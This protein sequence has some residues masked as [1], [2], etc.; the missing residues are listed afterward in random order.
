MKAVVM[1]GG[2]GSRLRPLTV[3][4][5]K[6]M[7]PIVGRPVMEHILHLLKEHGITD[8][9][10]TVQYMASA[11]EDYF[12]D[13]T[14]LGMRIAY[15][16]EEIPLGTAG[17]VKNAEHLL[18]EPFLVISGDAMTDYNLSD[19]IRYHQEKKAL[20]T[21]TLAHVAN[22]LEYGVITTGENG[23]IQQF[24]EKPSWGEVFSDTI[25][26]GIYVLDPKIF[27]YFE[28]ERVFDFSQDLFPMM[29]EK[30][31]PLYGY[32]AE[33]YWCDIGN[34]ATYM[35]AN[36]DLLHGR[37]NIPVPGTDIGGRVWVEEG[38]EIDPDAQI[39]GPV[40]L[41]HDC[42]IKGGVIVHGPSCVGPYTIADNHAQIDR[43][44][45]WNNSYIGE[46]A[47]LR[48]AL[49][50]TSCT[51]KG[52]AVMFE[53]AVIGDH[54]VINES[55]IVQA[56]VKIWPNKEIETGAVIANSIIWGS[57][58]RRALF[59]R[60]GVTGLVNVDIT[61][62]FAARLGAAYGAVLA[63]GAV[64]CVN[65]D[66]HRT[67]RMIKRA[68]ISGL[69]S[70][71]VNVWDLESVPLP[72]A[73]YY[74]RTTDAAGGVHIRLSPFDPRTVDIKFFDQ[75]GLDISKNIER[76]I[77]NLFF[78][79]DFRRVYL[80]DIG[81]ISYA[82]AVAERYTAAF[83]RAID[84]DLIRR[85]NF[86]LVVDYGHGAS[87]NILSPLFNAVSAD[88]IALNATRDPIRYSRTAEE[89]DRDK[90]VLASVT[91]TL[92]ADMGVRIDT[93]GER[94]YVV[95][96]LGRQID[97]GHLMGV[98]TDLI[99]R[100]QSGGSVVVPVTVPSVVEAI[101]GKQQGHITRTKV[102]PQALTTAAASDGTV[103]VGD[104]NG[105]FVFPELHPA[106]DGMFALMKL[107]EALARFNAKLSEVVDQL[108]P[109][110][111]IRTQVNCPWEYKGKVMRMLSEQYHKHRDEAID[112]VRIDL[113]PEEW[114]LVLPDADRPLFHVLAE[115]RSRDAAQALADKYARVVSGLQH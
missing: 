111:M 47:E 100:G 10:V 92:K 75:Y 52:K 6:P 8:V 42:K 79:E 85:R 80:D 4:R 103:L 49:V 99:L 73:R 28:K 13:G 72:V 48:G 44:V 9:V 58:G 70:A 61:P 60:Y 83:R 29:L 95:D 56:G 1:A 62:D 45:I 112:G 115:S 105:G 22:P 5:P 21:L 88:I 97:G 91:G 84:V 43:S 33:G 69:P 68:I 19:I 16:R 54:S 108:P 39:F 63:K 18:T 53:G 93:A 25:N 106:F 64:I 24:L 107:L 113:G 26:T 66:D 30:G 36:A 90:Q 110:H 2:E 11:I 57:Q 38:V 94:I 102:M 23:H 82:P 27:S 77:E 41:G 59:G 51:V 3:S 32:I 86:R 109:Y 76:K 114:V 35:Q 96:E 17:S 87:V 104:G 31:D 55:A 12:G 37:V 20:A 74:V 14:Q 50:G 89:F 78:R 81:N 67:P 7:V 40:Y 65:R 46:R 98:M 15:S 101:A 71:G 34:L